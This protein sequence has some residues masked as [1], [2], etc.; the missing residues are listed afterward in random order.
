MRNVDEHGLRDG[1]M[2]TATIATRAY[3]WRRLIVINLLSAVSHRCTS[4]RNN[5]FICFATKVASLSA[6]NENRPKTSVLPLKFVDR[7][8]KTFDQLQSR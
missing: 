8:N 3:D 1:S 6:P 2:L 7:T 4:S 5:L